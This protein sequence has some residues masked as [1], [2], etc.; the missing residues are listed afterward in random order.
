VAVSFG[1][2]ES[3]L[4]ILTS[5][6]LVSVIFRYWRL[7]VIVGYVFVGALIGPHALGLL[8]DVSKIQL[9]ADFGVVFLMFTVGLEFSIAKLFTL[10]Y[11]AFLLGASQ[12]AI[13]VI[14]TA[15]IGMLLGLSFTAAFIIGGIV[16]MSS[17][18]LV[19]KILSERSELSSTHG[20]NA[21]G[22]L[23]FQDMAVIPF[24]I[25]IATV[26]GTSHH[27]VI[28][29][30]TSTLL[31]SLFAIAAIY[32]VGRFLLRPSFHLIAKMKVIELFMLATLFVV[33]GAAWF[34]HQFGLSYALGA[35]LAG[36]MLGE[37]EFRHQIEVE[38][39][40]FRDLLLGLFF[41]SI[42]MLLNIKNWEATGLWI[43]LLLMAI[44]LGKSL[45]IIAL[46]RIMRF[47]LRTSLR[48]GIVLAQSG[49]FGFA[50]L[51]LALAHQLVSPEYAQVVLSALLISFAISPLLIQNNEKIT[52][53]FLPYTLARKRKQ[54][55]E[56][57]R[58]THRGLKDH[59]LIF[60]YGRVGQSIAQYLE[61]AGQPYLGVD[62]DPELVKSMRLS[63][64]KVFFGDAANPGILAVAQ[65][66]NAKA[67]V[68]CFSDVRL[69]IKAL[70][71]IHTSNQGLPTLVRCKDDA[72]KELLEQH[73]AKHIVVETVEE[74]L[75]MV[76]HLL[77]LVHHP[78]SDISVLLKKARNEE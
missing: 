51:T 75:T 44:F 36:I 52:R 63:G 76:Q 62:M 17:T 49:E 53:F 25:L 69:T 23:L 60:G 4:I 54:E 47:S 18:A 37:T 59:I 31:K 56:R 21:M 6:L 71:Q 22:I 64:E 34:T 3:I 46:S 66:K 74:S 43:G 55:E 15:A 24:L 77:V 14:A 40:P 58:K 35:F 9:F 16:A 2:L 65:I 72:E 57:M 19:M 1:I 7:P 48:T 27:S 39:R 13:S 11:S 41:I 8:P 12:V 70:S 73:G 38:I 10:R 29:I 67:A 5:A 28:F 30:L 61:K 42:G 32:W 68:I 20:M 45:L 50:I 26:S 33:M 78:V